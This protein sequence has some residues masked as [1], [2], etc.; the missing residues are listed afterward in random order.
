MCLR[1]HLE[2]HLEGNIIEERQVIMALEIYRLQISSSTTELR[3]LPISVKFLSHLVTFIKLSSR[4]PN[5]LITAGKR[6]RVA[7][8]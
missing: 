8:S 3:G 2:D 7:F 1:I 6:A 4:L 5:T